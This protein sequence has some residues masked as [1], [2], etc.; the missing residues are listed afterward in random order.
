[1]AV[2]NYTLGTVNI[3]ELVW[4]TLVSNSLPIQMSSVTTP[5]VH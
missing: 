4:L 3:I 5:L 2:H 1:M